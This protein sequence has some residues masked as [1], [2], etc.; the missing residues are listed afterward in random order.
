MTDYHAL[1]RTSPK[2]HDFIGTCTKCGKPGLPPSAVKEE[3]PNPGGVTE[4]Q[5]VL[6]A[7][8]PAE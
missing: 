4:G 3:C 7:I 5:A 2:G 8:D 1:E 6:N